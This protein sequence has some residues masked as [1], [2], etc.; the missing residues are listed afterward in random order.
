MDNGTGNLSK[1]AVLINPWHFVLNI[2]QNTTKYQRGTTSIDAVGTSSPRQMVFYGYAILAASMVLD[3]CTSPGHSSGFNIFM[4]DIMTG[5]NS[6][7]AA[8]SVTYSAGKSEGASVMNVMLCRVARVHVAN[9]KLYPR[10]G[11]SVV[12]LLSPP[13]C[14]A[15]LYLM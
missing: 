6:T 14:N 10:R 9:C 1:T 2:F 15:S 11:H 7:R 3:V 12:A 5:T 8:V 4:N 13:F